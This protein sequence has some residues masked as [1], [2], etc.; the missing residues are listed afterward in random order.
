MNS[1]VKSIA[2]LLILALA[3]PGAESAPRRLAYFKEL[4]GKL[5]N[6]KN[7]T[8]DALALKDSESYQC[9]QVIKAFKKMGGVV[10]GILDEESHD[11]CCDNKL[12]GVTCVYP[13]PT[14]LGVVTSM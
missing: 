3:L 4:A 11:G 6:F 12:V 7:A 9:P 1:A 8:G 14:F 10:D 13:E 5:N 2:S